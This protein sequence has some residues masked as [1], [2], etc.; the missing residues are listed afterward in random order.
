MPD[1]AVN[2]TFFARDRISS[3]FSKMGNKSKDF[4]NRANKA[5]K[6]ASGSARGFGDIIKGILGA[7]LLRRGFQLLKEGLGNFITQASLIEDATARFQPLMGSVEKA[8]ELVNALNKEAA[9][10]PFQ[11]EGISNIAS[12]LLPVMNGSIEDT[13]DTFK[14]LGDTAGGNMEKLSTITRGYT[15][16]LLKGKPDME[17]LNMIAEAGVPIFTLMADSMGITTN[18]LFEL[19][20]QGLLTTQDLTKTFRDITSEGGDFFQGMEIASKT[21][22]GRLSTLKDN[23]NLT[24]G[25]I[26]TVALPLLK[27][28]ADKGIEVAQSIK[29]WV[30][31]NQELIK[32]GFESFINIVK[33]I[34]E[35]LAPPIGAIIQAVQKLVGVIIDI[36]TSV[37]P[38]FVREN[39]S[40]ENSLGGIAF[41]FNIVAGFID[42]FATGLKFL[43]PILVPLIAIYAGWTIAQWA[44]NVAL[45][46]NPI[47]LIVAGV[48]LLIAG[49]GLLIE[50]WDA[51]TEAIGQ[52]VRDIWNWFSG[53]LDNPFFVALGV[54]FLPFITIPALI[55]KHWAPISQF[56]IDIWNNILVPFGVFITEVFGAAF[57]AVADAVIAAWQGV[58]DFFT[59]IWDNVIGPIVGFITDALDIVGGFLGVT[60]P[61]ISPKEIGSDAKSALLEGLDVASEQ[62]PNTKEVEAKTFSFSGRLDIAG[63]PE[64]STVKQDNKSTPGI[65]LNL[66]GVNP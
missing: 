14:M 47:G 48:A 40:L 13:I 59:W 23:I 2:T 22:T 16:A 38:G 64:G 18:K 62:A 51:I 28:F 12:Q 5:F 61:E 9:N 21:L 42:A 45:T 36:V 26:G 19:S 52:G 43:K 20:K 37:I 11:F 1:I 10:T 55:L 35:T 27:Q 7:Q 31:A 4:G 57:T 30:D 53:L 17:S 65:D 56:F 46:A 50:N 44:L 29:G 8:T 25:A 15:K 24:F 60:G 41:V 33:N 39:S 58:A 34:F 6:K 32:S 49:I 63:A 3:A 66:L 54:I